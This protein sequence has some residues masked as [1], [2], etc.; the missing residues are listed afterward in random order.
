M[1]AQP[2]PAQPIPTAEEKIFT[3]CRITFGGDWVWNSTILGISNASCV[4][5]CPHCLV[6]NAALKKGEAHEPAPDN[7]DDGSNTLRT[8][9]FINTENERY[10][11][12]T[13]GDKN[14]AKHYHNCIYKPL[15]GDHGDIIDIL[16]VSP[17]HI[18]LGLGLQFVNIMEEMCVSID[19]EVKEDKVE[20][21]E[22]MKAK[23]K[24]KNDMCEEIARLE[25]AKAEFQQD[26]AD[27]Q[28]MLQ[29]LN[30]NRA[31]NRDQISELK[32]EI[33][34]FKDELKSNKQ[35]QSQAADILADLVKDV[36]EDKGP[37]LEDFHKLMDD[38]ALKRV[39]YHSG[40]LIGNDVK[41]T[42]RPE[43][44]V[45]FANVFKPRVFETETGPKTYGSADNV[46]K[47]QELLTRFASCYDLYHRNT[48]LCKHEVELLAYRAA[49]FGRWFPVTFPNA[50]VK[51]KFHL[52]T[53]EVPRQA[54]RLQTVGMLI[55]QVTESIHPFMN[56][57]GYLFIQT[58]NTIER[59]KLMARQYNMFARIDHYA[60][61]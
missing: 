56:K 59:Q 48:P 49:N 38:L 57:V 6:T 40:A 31:M 58:Q 16:S 5:F 32:E 29:E 47:V 7:E 19:G 46:T 55:E 12:E 13:G 60:A 3:S 37:Y 42:L 51:R 8:L 30:Q 28:H 36:E 41:K 45:K 33:K 24:K 10:L 27:S 61:N 9:Q 15:I 44:I 34:F 22:R 14:K 21:C 53:H 23:M 20:Y 39:V 35:E 43:N 25:R 18:S 17:M 52:L 1:P 4:Y 50:A 2:I 26:L 54:R 11:E